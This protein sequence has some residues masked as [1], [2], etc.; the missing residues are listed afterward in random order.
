MAEFNSIDE[1][2]D[3]AINAEQEAVDFYTQLSSIVVNAEMKSTF[4]ELAKEEMEHKAKLK[5]VK[6]EKVFESSGQEKVTDLK[7]A[8][9]VEKVKPSPDMEYSD[10]LKLAMRKEKAAFRLYSALA[11]RASK[12]ELRK[13]FEELANEEAKHKLRFELEYDEYVLREN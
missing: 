10:A 2:L 8:D 5:K 9:Y 4:L 13:V 7:I 12:P 3:F 6:E 11:D 1:I